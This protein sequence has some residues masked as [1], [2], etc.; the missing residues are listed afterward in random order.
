MRKKQVI[1]VQCHNNV[2][3]LNYLIEFFPPDEFD[4]IIH[5]D[6]KSDIFR[7]IKRV[8]N[9]KF[10]DRV[11]VMWGRF[12]QVEATLNMFKLITPDYY[13]RI[14]LISGV[15]FPIK[16]P[17]YFSD[18]FKDNHNEYILSNNLPGKS[19]WSWGGRP[20]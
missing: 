2:E 8:S 7:K 13:S 1:C 3:M 12:S 14:H 15:D 16:S 5:V 4:F 11:D 9:V 18:F 17:E 6:K 19:T 20:I 10:S